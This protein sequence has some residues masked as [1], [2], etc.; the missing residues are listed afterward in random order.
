MTS[1][2]EQIEREVVVVPEPVSNS[3]VLERHAAFF[4]E[5][6]GIIDQL[7]ARPPMVMIQVLI[8]QI[9]LGNTNEFG[10]ELGLQ[11]SVLFDRSTLS[12]LQTTSTTLPNGTTTQ[13][14]ASADDQSRLQLQQ[15]QSAGQ[16]LT[17][18]SRMPPPSAGR[19]CRTSASAGRTA[20]WATA[21][22]CSRWPAK[23]SAC[24]SAPWPKTTASKSSSGRRS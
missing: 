2:F 17:A 21:A 11:D 22:W 4:D 13:T 1:A 23:T 14:I 16:Q 18:Q 5:V 10:I 15:R 7:D 3:L 19:A 6:K 20:S 8:A 24:C 12:N 9:D